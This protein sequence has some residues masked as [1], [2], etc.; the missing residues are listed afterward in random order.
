MI[1]VAPAGSRNVYFGRGM[2]N[3]FIN[4][5]FIQNLQANRGAIGSAVTVKRNIGN[6]IM[7]GDVVNSLIQ[8]GYDQELSAVANS[9]VTSLQGQTDSGRRS[10]QR[11]S[12]A[13]DLEPDRQRHSQSGHLQPTGPRRGT[14]HGRIAGNVT[15]SIVSVSVDPDPSGI[16][17]PVSSRTVTSRPSRLVHRLTSSCRAG[18]LSVK[19]EGTSQQQR[20]SA[21]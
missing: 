11:R 21:G 20:P 18:V 4:T 13:H 9:P 10:L 15:N 3:T 7:G 5:E 19:V 16:T 12:S 2:D 6:M 14:I 17:T 8:S 1:L